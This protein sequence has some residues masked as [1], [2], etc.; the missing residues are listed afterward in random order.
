MLQIKVVDV[1]GRNKSTKFKKRNGSNRF[2]ETK[3]DI[4]TPTAGKVVPS[5]VRFH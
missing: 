1:R 2:W 4:G 3:K 5:V